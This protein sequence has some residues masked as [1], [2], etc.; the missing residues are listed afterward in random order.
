MA[1]RA[2]AYAVHR[3]PGRIRFRVPERRGDA[4]F[5]GEV[6]QCLRRLDGVDHV[7]TNPVTASVLVHHQGEIADLARAA[8]GNDVGKLVEIVLGSPPLARTV[9]TEI[10]TIDETVRRVTN[11]E[12]DLATLASCGLL[13]MAAV[14]LLTGRQPVMAVS[15]GWYATELLRRSGA[16]DNGRAA[17]D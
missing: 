6:E 1:S 9:R 11:G 17:A 2:K 15:L 7:K 10:A 3:V 14:H 5:F 8:F 4:K 13:A 16:P 12:M